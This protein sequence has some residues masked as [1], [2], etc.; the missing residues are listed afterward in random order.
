MVSMS[1]RSPLSVCGQGV[2]TCPQSLRDMQR[3][4]RIINTKHLA[5]RSVFS[6]PYTKTVVFLIM[7]KQEIAFSSTPWLEAS[8][9]IPAGV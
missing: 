7:A 6:L 3:F 8:R 2:D 1:D 9:I 4:V 5:C